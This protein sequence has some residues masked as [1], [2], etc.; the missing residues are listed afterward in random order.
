MPSQIASPLILT[1]A[2]DDAA[3]TYFDALRRKHFPAKINHL[4]AHLTLF[5]HLPGAQRA[6]VHA[7]LQAYAQTF[8][9]LPLQV[10][11]LRSLGQGVAF[12][13]ENAQLRAMHCELQTAF[14]PYLTSQ[15]QQKLQ[16]HVTIQ[17]KV[18]PDTARQLLAELQSS[19]APFG[20]VGTGLQLWAYQGGPWE[21]LDWFPFGTGASLR[22]VT[23]HTQAQGKT[24]QA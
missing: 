22:Q 18:P 9:Q 4:S 1:L 16:P 12:T 2:L 15:D 13:L 21:K 14:A 23:L 24:P 7:Q 5:H 8:E 10:T 17:N 11:G 20:A 3:H 6:W 19:F